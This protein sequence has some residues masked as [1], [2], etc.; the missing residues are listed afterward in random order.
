M[1]RSPLARLRIHHQLDATVGAGDGPER[2]RAG[3]ERD[4]AERD[5]RRRG[6]FRGLVGAGAPEVVVRDDVAEQLP[7]ARQRTTVGHGEGGRADRRAHR[8][9][10][11]EARGSGLLL[12]GGEARADGVDVGQLRG[13]PDEYLVGG[14]RA[15]VGEHPASA[16]HGDVAGAGE[17]VVHERHAAAAEIAHE[18]VVEREV[19]GADVAIGIELAEAHRVGRVAPRRSTAAKR[20]GDLELDR[21]VH[22]RDVR[23]HDVLPADRPGR[24]A[25]AAA[26]LDGDADDVVRECGGDTPVALGGGRSARRPHVHDHPANGAV[27]SEVVLGVALPHGRKAIDA[28]RDEPMLGARDPLDRDRVAT[29]ERH[30]AVALGWSAARGGEEDD[31]EENE[32]I[33]RG[34]R[35]EE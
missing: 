29:E 3:R 28:I 12:G 23:H 11:A 10:H 34:T 32:A 21:A 19:P 22:H 35:S 16:V 24:V 7:A 5:R 27:G 25:H 8:V 13:A 33:H 1:L 17:P 9:A 31:S 20:G 6:E 30:E 26:V 14:A 4:A 15:G 18:A 2:V